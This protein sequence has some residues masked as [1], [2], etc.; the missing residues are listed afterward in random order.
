[1]YY[2]KLQLIGN[3]LKNNKI[4]L[5]YKSYTIQIILN[6][7]LRF[8]G[9]NGDTLDDLH[10]WTVS[11]LEDY[12]KSEYKYTGYL[13]DTK[14]YLSNEVKYKVVDE[15]INR[16]LLDNLDDIVQRNKVKAESQDEDYFLTIFD[17]KDPSRVTGRY[18]A[19]RYYD[20]G[21]IY[22]IDKLTLT[23][24]FGS[25]DEIVNKLKEDL[26]DWDIKFDG[27]E[28]ERGNFIK[29]VDEPKDEEDEL[30]DIDQNTKDKEI[31]SELITAEDCANVNWPGKDEDG[32]CDKV[33]QILRFKRAILLQG[34]PGTGKTKIAEALAYKWF[35]RND[36]RIDTSPRD[37]TLPAGAELM[38]DITPVDS[39]HFC[40]VQFSEEYS[41][42]DFVEGLKPD[43]ETG[44]W[45]MVP[46][47]LK[48]MCDRAREN[49]NQK[50]ILFIDEINRANTEA[51]IG[52]MLNLMEKRDRS[53]TLKSGSRLSMPYNLYIIATMNTID[54][55]AGTLNFATISRFAEIDIDSNSKKYGAK[56]NKLTADD[57]LT[58]KLSPVVSG[59]SGYAEL[60]DRLTLLMEI[61]DRVNT[62][63]AYDT[64]V[65]A[66][67]SDIKIG[68]RCLYT[69]YQNSDELNLAAEFDLLPELKSRHS[70][71][72]DKN[73]DDCRKA[74]E[75]F[76]QGNIKQMDDVENALPIKDNRV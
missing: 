39:Y 53:I 37:K 31:E 44:N 12:L 26:T 60:A 59:D 69:G 3:R 15:L 57:I 75:K 35:N 61:L 20:S 55:G 47:P 58:H 48:S 66:N 72:S 73:Y 18:D 32:F 62:R 52:E 19:Y 11:S 49:P 40:E 14:L 43:E 5:D 8:V 13:D 25:Y 36:G 24:Y 70:R 76:Y 71:L 42:S 46:G 63:I 67:N 21:L 10:P 27:F 56:G 51:V 50:F 7:N 41:Y 9:F 23:Q 74:I 16:Q 2:R 6:D 68:Y 54:R 29:Q 22:L 17:A 30:D 64:Q 34:P 65:S 4:S 33:L 28:N 1:M 45:K 38:Y